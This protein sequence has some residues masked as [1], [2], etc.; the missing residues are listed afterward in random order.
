MACDWR[1]LAPMWL[2]CIVMASFSTALSVQQAELG[3]AAPTLLQIALMVIFGP[4]KGLGWLH[5]S[6]DGRGQ[7]P[8]LVKFR[9]DPSRHCLLRLIVDED[10]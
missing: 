6:Y 5:F 8:R 1:S 9:D 3:A 10:R 4:P 2:C 7:P